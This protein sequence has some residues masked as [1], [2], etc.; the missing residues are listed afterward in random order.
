MLLMGRAGA[1][2]GVGAV[3]AASRAATGATGSASPKSNDVRAPC[4]RAVSA[5]SASSDFRKFSYW[6]RTAFHDL[7]AARMS[8]AVKPALS[9][10]PSASSLMSYPSLRRSPALMPVLRVRKP[11]PTSAAGSS[12]CALRMM[13]LA[14]DTPV[15]VASPNSIASVPVRTPVTGSG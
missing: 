6:R 3:G 15:K 2:G 13:P 11:R 5:A 4:R 10:A 8:S 14:Y 7:L 1:G 12:R 9:S